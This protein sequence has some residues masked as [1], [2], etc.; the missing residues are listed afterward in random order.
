[1]KACILVQ[2]RFEESI[3]II[4]VLR[5]RYS[6]FFLQGSSVYG[7]YDAIVELE[8][9]NIDKLSEITEELKQS[10]P[11]ITHIETIVERTED[12]QPFFQKAV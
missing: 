5:N 8:I 3:G 4:D 9:P 1:M 10:Q 12:F 2:T 6:K 7:W 11:D